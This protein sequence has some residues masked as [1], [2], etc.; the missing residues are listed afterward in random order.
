MPREALLKRLLDARRQR[1]VVIHGPAGS[2]KT[3]TLEAWR[4]ALLTLDYDVAWISLGPED[5]DL[6]PFFECLLTSLGGVYAAAVREAALLMGGGDDDPAAREHR[7][8]ALVQGL[9]RYPR[10]LVLMLDDVHQLDD[11]DVLQA[12]R[13]LVDYAPPNFH[14]VFSSRR[15]LPQALSTALARLGDQKLTAAFDLRDLRFSAAESE[16]FLREQL[17]RIGKRDALTLHQLTDGW[18]AGLQLFA[19]DMRAKG[20]E[21]YAPVRLRDAKA[22]AR[23]FEREVFVRVPAA[24]L[25]LLTR[26]AVCGRFCASLCASLVDQPQALAGLMEQLTQLDSS[27]LFIA[28]EQGRDGDTWYRVHPLLREVLLTRLAEAPAG[29]RRALHR[30]AWRWFEANGYADEAVRHAV[31]AGE[32]EA[33]AATVERCARDLLTRGEFGQMMTLVRRLPQ[34]VDAGV[35]LR[36]AIAHIHLYA[37]E[38]DALER[39]IAALAALALDARQ[40]TELA[41]LRGG[42]ALQRDDVDAALRFLPELDDWSND[43][44]EFMH[45]ARTNFLAWVHIAHGDFALARSILEESGARRSGQAAS[46]TARFLTGLSHSLEGRMVEAERLYREVLQDADQQGAT[47]VGVSNMASALLGDVLYE[48]DEVEAACQ[49]LEARI[50]LIEHSAIPEAMLRTSIVLASGHWVSGRQLEALAQLDRL[51]DYAGVRRLDRLQAHALCLRM[52]LE[53]QRGETRAATK[54]LARLEVLASR[55]ATLGGTASLEIGFNVGRAQVATALHLGDF[56]G[57]AQILRRLVASAEGAQRQRP[58]VAMRLQLGLVEQRRG[59]TDVAA[60]LLIDALRLGHRL[61][62]VRTLLD[63]SRRVPDALRMLQKQEMLDPVLSFYVDRL[64]LAASRG[65]LAARLATTPS[66]SPSAAEPLKERE[67]EILRLLAQ[68][69]PNKKIA[70]VIGLSPETVKWHLKNIYAKLGVAARDEAV[71]RARDFGL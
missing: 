39:D 20:S 57:A 28:R 66:R 36:T 67:L 31:H 32:V 53:Q 56:D 37:R 14:L 52:R 68:A 3:S 70:R 44:D 40:R 43:A 65:R 30:R 63:A 18:V 16:R 35:G 10:E 69:L 12:L 55:H 33:A 34:E 64:L 24:E 60:T 19:L 58:V 1:C 11:A 5:N 25:D 9:S 8:I 27:N 23:Y 15:A 54:A 17:G 29:E 21:T 22:F 47:F 59:R 38:L 6:T 42:L 62:L 26:V 51:E 49:L 46:L 41:L 50:D 71:A 61:G 13:W 2:G 48:V 4:Q 45:L 7:V